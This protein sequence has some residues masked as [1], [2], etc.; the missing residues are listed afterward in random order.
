MRKSA[1][2]QPSQRQTIQ[3]AITRRKVTQNSNTNSGK[4]VTDFSVN[5]WRHFVIYYDQNQEKVCL[6][7]EIRLW[8]FWHSPVP[9][10]Q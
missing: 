4:A 10:D 9:V 2:K 3:Q 8:A 7:N 5:A 6:E 1:N